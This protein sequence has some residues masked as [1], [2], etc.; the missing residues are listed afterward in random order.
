MTFQTVGD[1]LV[2]SGT[3]PAALQDKL[4]DINIAVSDGFKWLNSTF[5]MNMTNAPPYVNSLNTLQKQMPDI[6]IAEEFIL[7]I[8]P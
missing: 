2:F 7:T 6:Y 3:P 8:D 4:V 1:E 5:E